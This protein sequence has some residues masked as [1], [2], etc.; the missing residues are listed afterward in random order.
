MNECE[1]I[2]IAAVGSDDN[3]SVRFFPGYAADEIEVPVCA[4]V[5]SLVTDPAYENGWILA[6]SHTNGLIKLSKADMRVTCSLAWM[7]DLLEVPLV[8]HWI[9]DAGTDRMAAVSTVWPSLL[10]PKIQFGY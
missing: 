6:H 5:H 2:A 4:I 8:D 7:S 10:E 9:F 1:A 3:F